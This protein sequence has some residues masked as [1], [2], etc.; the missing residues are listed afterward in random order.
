MFASIKRIREMNK[1]AGSVAPQ[2]DDD[3]RL[4]VDMMVRDDSS[5]I[6]PFSNSQQPMLSTEAA[7]F[8]DSAIKPANYKDEIR[9][10]IHS[11]CIDEEEQEIYKVAIK[12]YYNHAYVVGRQNIKRSYIVS[13]LM[14]LMSVV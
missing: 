5:F 7:D 13:A 14:L 12:N 4:V 1:K 2:H 6:S 11:D 3:G 9:L 10:K 8:L